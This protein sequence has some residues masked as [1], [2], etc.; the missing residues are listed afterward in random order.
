MKQIPGLSEL[1]GSPEYRSALG[2]PAA[3]TEEYRLLAQ[4]E[5][6]RNFRFRHPVTGKELLLRVNCGS[7]MHL[8]HQIEYES[9]ALELLAPSGRTPRVL[10]TDGSKRYTDHGVSVMEYLPG[11]PLDYHRD[12]ERAAGVLADVHSVPLPGPSGLIEPA[13]PLRAVL[14]ECEEMLRVYLN[15]DL[16]PLSGKRK[17][18]ELLDLAWERYHRTNRTGGARC[19][20]NTELNN[21]N[22]LM[23]EE[24]DGPAGGRDWLIDWEKPLWSDPAQDIAHFL[25]PTTTFWKTDVILS[26]GETADFLTAYEASVSD[27]IDLT[28]LRERLGVFMPVT[29]MRGVTWCAMAWVQYQKEEKELSNDSTRRKLEAYLSDSFLE[30]IR[31]IEEA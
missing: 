18:R 28:G 7:Q 4:G 2:L 12:L 11:R 30:E 8:E 3:V 24:P 9:H 14:E 19:I 17:I 21:T 31:R 13:D 27:R 20:V 22:F 5:Y 29:C 26:P 15:S 25:V 16:P 6:N 1:V 10:Y 23:A